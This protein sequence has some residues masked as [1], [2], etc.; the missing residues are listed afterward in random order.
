MANEEPKPWVKAHLDERGV[1]WDDLKPKTQRAFNAFSEDEINTLNDLGKAFK[2][3]NLNKDL[4]V[5][6]VH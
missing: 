5:S 3:D 2:D 4:R 1:S 6:A